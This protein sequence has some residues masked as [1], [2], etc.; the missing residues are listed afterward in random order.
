MLFFHFHYMM[1]TMMSD[2]DDDYSHSVLTWGRGR[3]FSC[4]GSFKA[5][6]RELSSVSECLL[7]WDEHNPEA[8]L[9]SFS[10][11]CYWVRTIC[12]SQ[13][14][15]IQSLNFLAVMK[16]A[17]H[18]VLAKYVSTLL[19]VLKVTESPGDSENFFGLLSPLGQVYSSKMI[20]YTW[21]STMSSPKTVFF[22]CLG[23]I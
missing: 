23:L 1:M 20:N 19:F 7:V 12:A 3:G 6:S 21:R 17:P 4:G 10:C 14:N 22:P 18:L 16:S 15:L 9:C 2:D 5:L 13:E 11:Q 8:L